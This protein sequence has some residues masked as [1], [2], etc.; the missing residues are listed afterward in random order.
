[1]CF[2]G[3]IPVEGGFLLG[4]NR[5]EH[6]GRTPALPPGEFPLLGGSMLMPVD[7]R[8]GG[9]WVALRSD[10]AAMV[11]LN[12]AF[13]NHERKPAYKQSRG[14]IIP[15]LMRA[16]DPLAAIHTLDLTDMEPFT[17]VAYQEK[18]MM[19]RWDGAILHEQMPD[20]STGLCISSA[21]LYNHPQQLLR[22]GWFAD[23][24]E[25][26]KGLHAC[27]LLEGV[28][29]GGFGAEDTDFVLF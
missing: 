18:L 7:G 5:D 16:P 1:M 23:Y 3:F 14:V 21:T 24:V 20:P 12:G 11:L 6:I 2:V 9:T 15:Q 28:S 8:A 10:G 22:A 26:E 29:S 27:A 25:R 13:M 4:S 19:W 17:L